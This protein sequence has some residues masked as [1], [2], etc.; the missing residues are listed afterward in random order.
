MGFLKNEIFFSLTYS[1]I[2]LS[3]NQPVPHEIERQNHFLQLEDQQEK[4]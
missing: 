1:W 3:R 2:C 4:K